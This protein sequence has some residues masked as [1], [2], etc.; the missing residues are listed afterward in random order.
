MKICRCGRAGFKDLLQPERQ[1]SFSFFI[2]Y[3]EGE[4]DFIQ[5]ERAGVFPSNAT[6]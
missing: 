4:R 2:R 6:K 3:V 5:M 1:I